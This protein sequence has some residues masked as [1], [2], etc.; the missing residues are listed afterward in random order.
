[1][2]CSASAPTPSS[3]GRIRR[4]VTDGL[5]NVTSMRYDALGQLLEATA[6]ARLMAPLAANAEDAIDP[7]RNS[8]PS[9]SSLPLVA[10]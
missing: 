1:V 3:N 2:P 6:P 4:S 7:F 8:F 10:G 5:G 9:L